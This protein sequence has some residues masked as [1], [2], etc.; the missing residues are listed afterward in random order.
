[1]K[2]L[3]WSAIPSRTIVLLNKQTNNSIPFTI[4]HQHIRGLRGKVIE[5]LSQ[6][7]STPPQVL[8][9][10]EHHMNQ[11]ELQHTVIDSYNLGASYC[12]TLYVKGG[13]CILVQEG[14]GCT[15][16]D[17]AKFCKDKDFEAC[18]CKIYLN[19]KRLRIITIYR[20]P[21]S[22]FATFLIKLDNIL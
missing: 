11:D 19:S 1:M 16:C 14:L 21:S 15:C 20:A 6:L 5:L 3:Q 22:N 12:R 9:F 2:I 4:Y 18:A 10:S 8:F 17:L 13:V 7:I